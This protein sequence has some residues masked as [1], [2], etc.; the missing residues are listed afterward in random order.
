MQ[1][2]KYLKSKSPS[3]QE[4]IYELEY[5]INNI[6]VVLDQLLQQININK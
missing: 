2:I 5:E 3:L 1:L 6:N 4:Q